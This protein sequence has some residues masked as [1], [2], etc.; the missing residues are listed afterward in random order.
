MK[1]CTQTAKHVQLCSHAETKQNTHAQ[2]RFRSFSHSSA[3]H[4]MYVVEDA[5]L[6]F[7][8]FKFSQKYV[9]KVADWYFA[10]CRKLN[11]QLFS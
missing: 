3:L 8:F 9:F 6:P 1:T 5:R 2:T 7:F 10:H 4:L 11:L